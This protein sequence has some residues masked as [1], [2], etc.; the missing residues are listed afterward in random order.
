MKFYFIATLKSFSPKH[1]EE[2]APRFLIVKLTQEKGVGEEMI[3]DDFISYILKY[4][5]PHFFEFCAPKTLFAFK[6]LGGL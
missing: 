5:E 1:T 3:L 4:V 2:G 6:L